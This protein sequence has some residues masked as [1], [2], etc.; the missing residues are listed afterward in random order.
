MR[1]LTEARAR[2]VPGG[3]LYLSQPTQDVESYDL[4]FV[5]HLHHF[6]S[7]HVRRYALKAGFRELGLVVGHEL[8]PNFSLHLFVADGEIEHDRPWYGPPSR[9]RCRESVATTTRSLAELD[10]TLSRLR[11]EERRVAV[12]SLGEVFALASAYSTLGEF[13]FVCGL[14]DDPEDRKK[15]CLRRGASGELP[16]GR[17]AGAGSAC[18]LA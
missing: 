14:E 1:F 15:T 13:P 5:D 7:E 18:I 8:M 2:L 6:T 9:T 11:A 4:F 12:F 10:R 3:L 17:L 16:T